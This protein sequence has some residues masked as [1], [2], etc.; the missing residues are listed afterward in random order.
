MKK[1][2]TAIDNKEVNEEP[3]SRLIEIRF[4]K[5]KDWEKLEKDSGKESTNENN[6]NLT[7]KGWK[8]KGRNNIPKQAKYKIRFINTASNPDP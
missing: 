4:D 6:S 2:L 5:V 1:Y 3:D 8:R 7:K